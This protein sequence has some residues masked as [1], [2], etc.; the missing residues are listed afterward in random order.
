MQNRDSQSISR[1]TNTFLLHSEYLIEY[2][3]NVNFFPETNW[4]NTIISIYQN[5]NSIED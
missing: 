5:H 3:L 1:V 2:F 4:T